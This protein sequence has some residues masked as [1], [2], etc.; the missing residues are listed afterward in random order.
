MGRPRL[1]KVP[2]LPCVGLEIAGVSIQIAN[3]WLLAFARL[4]GARSLPGCTRR[5]LRV[6]NHCRED[7]ALFLCAARLPALHKFFQPFAD[8]IGSGRTQSGLAGHFLGH[9]LRLLPQIVFDS[10]GPD[11][12]FHA[13]TV[14]HLRSPDQQR[15]AVSRCITRN[16]CTL[17]TPNVTKSATDTF[18]FFA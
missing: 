10:N 3:R 16:P 18:A 6:A 17:N 14:P 1:P 7:L 13:P 12:C 4:Q 5:S 2:G 11:R 15:F 8:H 9:A